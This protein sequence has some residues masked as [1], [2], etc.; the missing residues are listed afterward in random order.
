MTSPTGTFAWPAE[1]IGEAAPEGLEGKPAEKAAA[2][3]DTNRSTFG[4]K[5]AVETNRSTLG[6]RADK[7]AA[8]M[9][10][11]TLGARA[12]KEATETKRS[13]LG[14]RETLLER[15]APDPADGPPRSCKPS[16]LGLAA[17]R[18]GK[19]LGV[20]NGGAIDFASGLGHRKL[21][22]RAVSTAAATA[23][24]AAGPALGAGAAGRKLEEDEGPPLRHSSVNCRMLRSRSSGLGS[25]GAAAPK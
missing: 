1:N 7:E 15:T 18:A 5:E 9:N 17:S 23:A 14:A 10:R 21:D 4:G 13:T 24:R 2:G 12:D 22:A 11:S 3:A 6:A 8:E 20:G 19:G 25:E 16:R